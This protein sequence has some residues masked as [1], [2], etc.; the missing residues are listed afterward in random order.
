MAFSLSSS[1]SLCVDTYIHFQFGALA[2]LV[3]NNV[4]FSHPQT[5]KRTSNEI[6]AIA[7]LGYRRL[8]KNHA[9]DNWQKVSHWRWEEFAPL[10]LP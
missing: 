4:K 10:E 9:V 8:G 5:T 1:G 6:N 2:A 7:F 3:N